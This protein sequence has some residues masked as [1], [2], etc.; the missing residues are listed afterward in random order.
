[1]H[2]RVIGIGQLVFAVALIG[3]GIIG[4]VTD[5]FA[6]SWQPVPPGIAWHNALAYA[7]AALLLLTGIG[8]FFKR[9]A[10]VSALIQTVNLFGWV[11]LLRLDGVIA[12]PSSAGR[13]LGVGENLVLATGAWTLWGMM[14]RA[15][16]KSI[17]PFATGDTAMTIARILFA[18]ALPLIG[19]S[20]IVFADDTA[21]LIPAWIPA[22]VGFAYFTGAADFAAGLAI[23]FMVVPRLAATL[24]AIMMSL[25]TIL[26]WIPAAVTPPMTRLAWTALMASTIIS[27]GAW[28]LA[29]SFRDRSWLSR[30][31]KR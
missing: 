28:I 29:D 15:D 9:T 18:L 25:F 27:G 12:H 3:L 8:L 17:L 7:S 10:Q 1:M 14:A 24:A 20:H 5:D 22:H 31:G 6:M 13:W 16:R 4:F 26:I 23:L 19:Q 30:P 2:M 21:S 11:V